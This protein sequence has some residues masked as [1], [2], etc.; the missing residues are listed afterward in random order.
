MKRL[1]I[2][3]PLCVLLCGCPPDSRPGGLGPGEWF[4]VGM[5]LLGVALLGGMV[6]LLL[7]L[8]HPRRAART[9]KWVGYDSEQ[10][11]GSRMVSEVIPSATAGVRGSEGGA[12]EARIAAGDLRSR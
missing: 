6:G 5:A 4:M 10:E 11:A 12:S 7:L 1:V 2:C 9:M 8:E 3:L